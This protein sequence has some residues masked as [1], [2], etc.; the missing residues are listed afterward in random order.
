MV[1][2]QV[3]AFPNPVQREF[4]GQQVNRGLRV[5][6]KRVNRVQVRLLPVA[7][8]LDREQTTNG[9]CK[10]CWLVVRMKAWLD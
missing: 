7:T 8:C 5:K 9:K 1:K 10:T 4:R 3:R 6:V 2:V